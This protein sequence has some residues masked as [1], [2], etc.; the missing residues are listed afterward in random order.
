VPALGAAF[1]VAV[2]AP[3]LEVHGGGQDQ[4]GRAGGVGRI[5]VGDD[6]EVLR[7]AGGAHPVG[8][9]GR[10]L[11]DVDDLGPHEVDGAVLKAAHDLHDGVADLGVERAGGQIPDAFGLLPVLAVGDEH[12][13]GK[14]VAERADLAGRAAGGRLAREREGAVARLGV[15][16]HEKMDRVDELVG[17]DAALVLVEAHAPEAQQVA[18]AVADEV[19]EAHEAGLEAFERFVVIA[20]DE[21][22]DEV[23]GVWLDGLAELLE[24]DLPVGAGGAA[25][26]L[27]LDLGAGLEAHGGRLGGAQA[28]ALLLFKN[29]AFGGVGVLVG[30]AQAVADV[31]DAGGEDGVLR[32]EV[33][34]D[35]AAADDLA[36]QVVRD[37]KVA[38]GLEDDGL[39]GEVGRHVAV[40]RQVDDLRVRVRELAVGHAR[41]EHGVGLGHVVAPEDHRVG[42]LDVAVVVGG[43]VDAEGLVEAHDSGRHAESGV[44]VDVVG[45]EAALPE[46]RGGV[47]LG[48]GVLAGAHERDARGPLFGVDT[49]ELARHF[50]E[51]LVPGDGFELAVLVELAV[52]AAHERLRQTVPAVHDLG[53]EVALDAVEAAVDGRVGVALRGDDAAVADADLEA[54]ARAAEAAHAPVPEMPSSDLRALAA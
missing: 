26:V 32:D 10:R 4:V 28:D 54:A 23:E 6:H 25:R 20:L 16:A 15:L 19:G 38:V 34:V 40:G 29:V 1:G 9:V 46:L 49:L 53:V 37:S 33:L 31:G 47:G 30:V 18:L 51:G 43:L 24:L 45:A 14:T 41:P 7:I 5:D 21:R 50:V 44:R 17:P 3:L 52:G 2:E 12:V 13:G 8:V 36:D 11:E 27:L 39:V 35:G 42:E 48:N 22:G